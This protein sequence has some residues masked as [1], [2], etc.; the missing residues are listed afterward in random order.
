MP[1]PLLASIAL[2]A[3]ASTPQESPFP[4]ASAL[5]QG[6]SPAALAE[7]DALVASFVEDDE[8]VG[9]ELLVIKNGRTLLH[10]AYGWNDREHE[11][12]MATGTVF[13]V[14]SMT[15]PLIGAAILMLADDGLVDLDDRVAQYLPAFD[16]EPTAPITLEQL[17]L[18]TSGLPMSLLM[19][20]DLG[21]LG[22]LQ[23]AVALGAG[24]ALESP[25]GTG[26]HYSDQGTDTLTA[27]I[28][29][30][31]GASAADF[32]RERLLEPL[33]MASSA[34]LMTEGHP[35]RARACSAYIGD[36]GAWKRYW[37]PEDPSFFPFFLGSQGLYA[38]LEDY[39]RFLELYLD[40]GRAAG[41]RLLGTRYVRNALRPGPFPVPSGTGFPD[42]EL[43]Y[44]QLMQLW[45][46]VDDAGEE[47]VVVFGHTGSDG[48]HAWA[49]PG[50]KAMA[51]Y[52]TQSRGTIT[53]LRVEEALAA[54]FLG[55]PFD[56]NRVAPPLEPLLGYYFEGE[57]DTYRAIVRDGDG[58]AL[59]IPGRA[60]VALDYVGEDR[61]RLRPEPV[62]V[63]EFDRAPDGTV[64]GYHIGA[65]VERRFTPASDLPSAEE[66]AARVA[67]THRIDRLESLGPM[68]IRAEL[69]MPALGLGGES[70]LL[71]AWPDR[72]RV[73]NRFAGQH[74]RAA[75]DGERAWY[76]AP[77]G[78]DAPVTELEGERA[79]ATRT[80]HPLAR[81]GDW[82]RWH[83]RMEV[84]QR[85]EREEGEVLVVRLGDA[86]EP[87]PTRFVHWESGR[88]V[89]ESSVVL[90][91]GLGRLGQQMSFGDF[92]DVEGMLLPHAIEIEYATPMLGTATMHTTEVELG[93]AV[94]D[95]MFRLE[96]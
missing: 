14:R 2:F 9:A 10:E 23:D 52:F 42:L 55:A 12:P 16:V 43:R 94:T 84:I 49:F 20:R 21:T 46:R 11:R 37:S 5:E 40:R 58:L 75:W 83:P 35:L 93:V 80:D 89:H 56:P 38:S 86:S 61:W 28:E 67:E 68:R 22:S 79:E 72:A 19:G 76:G 53:G 18:H 69:K 87:A 59:E 51:L 13:C 66:L 95:A 50:E 85:L 62:N 25:P 60:V 74:E 63:L 65:H 32:V 81:F 91:D 24:H 82:R 70:I 36:R 41:G 1:T 15:K 45:V 57:G 92:R 88:L 96:E 27:V 54:L 26:F 29:E 4:P 39:A 44:G 7:L 77:L 73:D 47:E 71:L 90:A 8:V 78:G 3:P 30:V 17:L 48:T 34:C 6:V 31:T 64:V 33:G